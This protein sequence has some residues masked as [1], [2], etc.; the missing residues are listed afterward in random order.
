MLCCGE[1]REKETQTADGDVVKALLEVGEDGLE[2]AVREA[3][4]A[5]AKD[6]REVRRD[7]GG[8]VRVAGL[9][10]SRGDA[11]EEREKTH[12]RAGAVSCAVWQHRGAV[13]VPAW[14]DGVWG[15]GGK[16]K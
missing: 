8:E 15:R 5:Q 12:A 7:V 14:S 13:P 1:G 4:L 6:D 9:A 3:V 2:D 11:A 10:H 16:S